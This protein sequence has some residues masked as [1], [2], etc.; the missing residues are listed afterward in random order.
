MFQFTACPTYRLCIHLWLTGHDS[1]RVAPFGNPRIKACL[2]A[3]RGLSQPTTSFFGSNLQGI[4]CVPLLDL[5]CRSLFRFG[6]PESS[7]RTWI[8]VLNLVPSFLNLQYLLLMTVDWQFVTA[9]RLPFQQ[10][11]L[12]WDFNLSGIRLSKFFSLSGM[13]LLAS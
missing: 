12:L 11:D 4:H 5:I 8:P 6:L 7:T 2:T 13:C 1:S 10:I 3:P 9:I